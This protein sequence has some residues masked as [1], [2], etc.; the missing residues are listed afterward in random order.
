MQARIRDSASEWLIIADGWIE[1]SKSGSEK[2][3]NLKAGFKEADSTWEVHRRIA[4]YE[5]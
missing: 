1:V 4:V 2:W 5:D 3:P